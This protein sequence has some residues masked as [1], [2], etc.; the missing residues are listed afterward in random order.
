MCLKFQLGIWGLK[1][2]FGVTVSER[3]FRLVQS[4]ISNIHKKPHFIH[5][6]KTNQ[7]SLPN[8]VLCCHQAWSLLA[9]HAEI[10][11]KT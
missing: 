9:L 2:N 4:P 6:D 7:T 5:N 3:R 1:T 11:T 8:V 10:I